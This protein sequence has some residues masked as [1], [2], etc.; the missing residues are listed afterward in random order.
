MPE[1]CESCG[2]KYSD[3]WTQIYFSKE[4]YCYPPHDPA[5]INICPDC[6]DGEFFS[7]EMHEEQKKNTLGDRQGSRGS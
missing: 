6:E 2:R 3:D 4:Q 7:E 1:R 5:A